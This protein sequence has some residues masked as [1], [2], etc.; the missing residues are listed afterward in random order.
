MP[1][2]SSNL[3]LSSNS[4]TAERDS[5]FT[6]GDLIKLKSGL[7]QKDTRLGSGTK[8]GFATII[9]IHNCLRKALFSGQHTLQHRVSL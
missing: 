7:G 5:K 8:N 2:C 3:Y 4:N 9:T 6:S 1:R